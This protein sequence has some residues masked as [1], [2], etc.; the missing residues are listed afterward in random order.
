MDHYDN[1]EKR[2]P[3][4]HGQLPREHFYGIGT[5]NLNLLQSSK[6]ILL[7]LVVFATRMVSVGKYEGPISIP[8]GME[9]CWAYP[10]KS[11]AVRELSNQH[12]LL[13]GGL[14]ACK[15]HGSGTWRNCGL[16]AGMEK[17]RLER[18]WCPH[19]NFPQI[20]GVLKTTSQSRGGKGVIELVWTKGQPCGL[21]VRSQ[22]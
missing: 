5:P 1:W 3:T 16:V 10:L 22:N 13:S 21:L 9:E 8:K 19:T 18:V 7:G 14:W 2:C 6:D 11:G 17:M 12:F 15:A 20:S 4:S